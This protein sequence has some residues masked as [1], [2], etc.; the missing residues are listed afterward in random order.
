MY[1]DDS[2]LKAI[3]DLGPV[4]CV[5]NKDADVVCT[6]AGKIVRLLPWKSSA[7]SSAWKSVAS[8]AEC[9]PHV[10]VCR[11]CFVEVGRCILRQS[12]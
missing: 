12:C 4:T 7:K 2:A 6:R 10:V 8:Y 3:A 9:D 11:L 1:A 5:V